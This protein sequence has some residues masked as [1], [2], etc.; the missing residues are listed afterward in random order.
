MVGIISSKQLFFNLSF[1]LSFF[2]ADLFIGLKWI[3]D[4]PVFVITPD[5]SDI[6]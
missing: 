3:L 5:R 4:A 2:P 1:L 6:N